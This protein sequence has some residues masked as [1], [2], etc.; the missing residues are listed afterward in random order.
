[1][2]ALK[3]KSNLLLGQ[4]DMEFQ[5]GLL[6][7]I[8]WDARLIGVLGAR[9]AGKTTLLLQRMGLLDCAPD[10]KLYLSLDDF[11]FASHTLSST[12]ETFRKEGGKYLFL[13]EVHKYPNWAREV[14]NVYDFYKDIHLVFTGSSIIEML[15]LEVDL[16]RRAHIYH[17]NGFSFREFL[18]F[19]HGFLQ[20]VLSLEELLASH[21]PLATK[22]NKI[23]PIRAFKQYLEYG[24]YPFFKEDK[25]NYARQLSAVVNLTIS[26]D[27]AFIEDIDKQQIQKINQL[28]AI[29][30]TQVPFKPN[31][32]E[33]SKTLGMGRAT[34]IQYLH[35]L[36]KARLIQRVFLEGKGFGPLEKP[37]KLLLDNPNLFQ[38]VSAMP[39]NA[40]SLRE[41]FFVNQFRNAGHTVE[42]A[43]QGDFLIDHQ[44]ALEVGGANK[45]FHQVASIPH[46]Y[47]AADDI[48]IGSG[49][50]IPLWL[51]G[52]LY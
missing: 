37:G 8:N 50:R 21:V 48:E 30:S 10:E 11:Y 20:Q 42:L 19:E 44:Y 2:D 34:L 35:Y 43:K 12:I 6:H 49:N 18:A 31:I 39:K 15:A 24:Y 13:D 51:F 38:A 41:S 27:L 33:L 25:V 29:L 14:K 16:S 46:S 23:K 22:F 36:E 9:G 3:E 26:Y 7:K 4:Q 5:R 32:T 28:L 40:G 45:T 1:M 47:I 52:M 17:L